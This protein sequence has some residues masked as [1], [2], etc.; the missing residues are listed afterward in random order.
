MDCESVVSNLFRLQHVLHAKQFVSFRL[1]FNQLTLL[2]TAFLEQRMFP[3]DAIHEVHTAEFKTELFP[4]RFKRLVGLAGL[5]RLFGA[6]GRWS[7]PAFS[8][9][10]RALADSFGTDFCRRF[11]RDC[12]AYRVGNANR[13][14]DD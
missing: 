10:N 6:D 11:S 1:Q 2:A 7:F 3:C 13:S 9:W 4:I 8:L 12:P 14:A 5:V